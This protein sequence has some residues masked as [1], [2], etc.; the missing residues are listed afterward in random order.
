MD[1]LQFVQYVDKTILPYMRNQ[2]LAAYNQ[3][4]SALNMKHYLQ[5][6]NIAAATVVD[7]GLPSK[8]KW[9]I[10]THIYSFREAKELGLQFPTIEQY[11]ELLKCKWS[12]QQYD[13]WHCHVLGPDGFEI[14]IYDSCHNKLC[15]WFDF[16]EEDENFRVKGCLNGTNELSDV[17]VGD[18]YATLFVIPTYIE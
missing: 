12:H 17:Y 8:T 5:Q 11:E 4:K 9:I 6:H 7:F 3:G 15:V 16:S 18:K 14:G 10:K 1:D 13:A 2:L